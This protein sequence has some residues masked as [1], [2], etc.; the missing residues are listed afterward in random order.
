IIGSLAG[1]S[2]YG[3]V[4]GHGFISHDLQLIR[5]QRKELT[6][7]MES[8]VVGPATGSVTSVDNG[9]QGDAFVTLKKREKSE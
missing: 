8:K 2:Y 6:Q 9:E 5:E 4:A 7:E 3:P 1:T